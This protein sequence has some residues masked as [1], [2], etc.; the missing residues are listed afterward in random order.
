[1]ADENVHIACEDGNLWS[2]QNYVKKNP[3]FDIN[4]PDHTGRTCLMLAAEN[5]HEKIADFLIHACH[6]NITKQDQF[7]QRSAVHLACRK[8]GKDRV[9][10]G[11]TGG[12]G[13]RV[14]F[15]FLKRG[16][17]AGN[18]NAFAP[19]AKRHRFIVTVV[20]PDTSTCRKKGRLYF[21]FNPFPPAPPPLRP[22]RLDKKYLDDVCF[23]ELI[24]PT[25]RVT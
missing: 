9:H 13:G 7:N 2:V 1:M 5:G 22:P 10:A 15:S 21:F 23:G 20:D 6:A 11:E 25:T 3:S 16:W 19:F 17:L 12:E 4:A 8:V 24:L 14:H 18:C